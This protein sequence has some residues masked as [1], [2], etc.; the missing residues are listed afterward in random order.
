MKTFKSLLML[1][2]LMTSF[3]ACTDD[4]ATPDVKSDLTSVVNDEVKPGP[5][6]TYGQNSGIGIDEKGR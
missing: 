2:A 1:T 5:A 6:A 3:V 4:F